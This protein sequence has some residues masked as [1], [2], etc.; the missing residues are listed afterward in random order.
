MQSLLPKSLNLVLSLLDDFS[1]ASLGCTS[2]QFYNAICDA[3]VQPLKVR[4]H[5][6]LE[7][8][9]PDI[10]ERMAPFQRDAQLR[11]HIRLLGDLID[12]DSC[13]DKLLATLGL[14]DVIRERCENG[15]LD[16]TNGKC[17][18]F[19]WLMT[20]DPPLN[21]LYWLLTTYPAYANLFI[22][23][24]R[25]A[26]PDEFFPLLLTIFV[27]SQRHDALVAF[28]KNFDITTLPSKYKMTPRRTLLESM[29]RTCV[30]DT[31][32]LRNLLELAIANGRLDTIKWIH[33]EMPDALK[34]SF[35]RLK[36]GEAIGLA[37]L[38]TEVVSYMLNASGC[39]FDLGDLFFALLKAKEPVRM[40]EV[41]EA[42]EDR[43]HWHLDIA[44][45]GYLMIGLQL[46]NVTTHSYDF[47]MKTV[48]RKCKEQ[49]VVDTGEW[50]KDTNSRL[51][52]NLIRT[53][54]NFDLFCHLLRRVKTLLLKWPYEFFTPHRTL[55]GQDLKYFQRLLTHKPTAWARFIEDD[56]TPIDRKYQIEPTR[57]L[58]AVRHFLSR[59][60][61]EDPELERAYS[62]ENGR[63]P[64]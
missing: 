7:D 14:F 18:L 32:R 62:R 6:L 36:Q 11:G 43:M 40:L 44:S 48:K 35:S 20:S 12:I 52:Q 27:S 1:F 64:L 47:A 39:S 9:Y 56:E 61:T 4:S 54:V 60:A 19:G 42:N 5:E 45:F 38:E 41:F 13:D 3:S 55:Q 15:T 34:K 51:L 21:F 17:H 57:T 58:G 16:I 33:E 2:T 24:A 59:A 28:I 29:I 30:S 31:G 8:R 46:G 25:L 26:L 63:P 22:V 49:C 10:Y 53:C 50:K 37:L 23:M